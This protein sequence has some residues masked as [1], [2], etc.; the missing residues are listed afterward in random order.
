MV[1]DL[2]E[3]G[4][5]Y[6]AACGKTASCLLELLQES[7]VGT[8]HRLLAMGCWGQHAGGLLLWE[9]RG[10]PHR[11]CIAPVNLCEPHLLLAGG[12]ANA[13]AHRRP[14][15]AAREPGGD[16]LSSPRDGH[17]AARAEPQ[18]APRAKLQTPLHRNCLSSVFQLNIF[19][20]LPS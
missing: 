5:F 19:F 15:T 14:A 18:G 6:R 12:T 10:P 17:A 13:G 16:F 11:T 2:Q 3:R 20:C 9:Q 4:G 1:K 7:E 8:E